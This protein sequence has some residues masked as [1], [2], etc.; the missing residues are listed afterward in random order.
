[1]VSDSPRAQNWAVSPPGP[2]QRDSRWWEGVQTHPPLPELAQ[3]PHPLQTS[4]YT[5][6]GVVVAQAPGAVGM[7]VLSPGLM[8]LRARGTRS[9][10]G[11]PFLAGWGA[12]EVRG[13]ASVPPRSASVGSQ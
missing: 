4:A 13:K 1:M 9:T 7:K 11:L 5:E 3:G 12:G 10:S 8:A 6:L 2:H